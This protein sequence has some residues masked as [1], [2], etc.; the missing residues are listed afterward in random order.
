MHHSTTSRREFLHW[1]SISG[2]GFGLQ[3]CEGV[4][5]RFLA[6]MLNLPPENSYFSQ[7]KSSAQN[8]YSQSLAR[9]GGKLSRH[10]SQMANAYDVLV[11]GSGYGGSICAAELS[12]ALKP[13]KTIAMLERGKEWLPGSFP[14]TLTSVSNAMTTKDK[15]GLF[16]VSTHPDMIVLAGSALGGTSVINANVAKI[17][18]DSI[19]KNGIWPKGLNGDLLEPH[20]QRVR[21]ILNVRPSP[22]GASS[23]MRAHQMTANA[24]TRSNHYQVLDL[25]VNR[26]GGGDTSLNAQGMIQRNCNDCGDCMTGCNVGAKNT[27]PYNYLPLARQNGAQ[28]FCEGEVSHIEKDDLG[29][30]VQVTVRSPI[31]GDWAPPPGVYNEFTRK[32][33]AKVVILTAGTLG[34]TGILLRSGRAGL[35]MS[36]KLGERFSGNGDYMSLT[37]GIAPR[38]GFTVGG[39]GAYGGTEKPG[40]SIQ[41]GIQFDQDGQKILIEDLTFP[42]GVVPLVNSM[43]SGVHRSM[44]YLAMGDDHAAG[45]IILDASGRPT[46]SWPNLNR[47]DL[48]NRIKGLLEEQAATLAG[49]SDM[50]PRLVDRLVG[51]RVATAHP[52]GGCAMGESADDGV[53]NLFGNVFTGTGQNCHHGLYVADGAAIPSPLGCNP[54]LTISAVATH[55]AKNIINDDRYKDIFRI[56]EQ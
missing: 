45:Q 54:F 8:D 15:L 38:A 43:T 14:D 35:P 25:A 23:K 53:V 21:R 40:P 11:I 20:F 2:L 33:R 19:F 28:I 52:L 46:V 41:S 34:T 4:S 26:H 22:V 6:E 42:R 39:E 24:M 10:A 31:S 18:E 56:E 27:L 16:D 17:P 7:I 48:Y 55:I 13:G 12:S 9:F 47:T 3:S 1:L 29:Y 44:F 51:N 37:D 36:K 30:T 49:R 32:I 50:R 5:T